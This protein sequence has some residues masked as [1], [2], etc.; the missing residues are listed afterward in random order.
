LDVLRVRGCDLKVADEIRFSPV[1]H[2]HVNLFGRH[3]LVLNEVLSTVIF[4]R[5]AIP[6][7][8]KLSPE[9]R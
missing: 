7:P 5:F 9:T 6:M 4:A 1:V 3:S 2:G 8:R